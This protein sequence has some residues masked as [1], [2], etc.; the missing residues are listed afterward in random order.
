MKRFRTRVKAAVLPRAI[1]IGRFIFM[2]LAF[3]LFVFFFWVV[4]LIG[5]NSH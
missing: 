3:L 5:H 4:S 1:E 2:A